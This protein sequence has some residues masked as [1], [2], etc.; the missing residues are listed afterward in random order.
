MNKGVGI[1]GK[2]Y[3]IMFRNDPHAADSVDRVLT[4][5]MIKLD[6]SSVEYLYGPYTDLST[7]YTPGSRLFF[8]TLAARLRG[9][10]DS[11]TVDNIILFCRN[12]VANCDTDT[13]EMIFGGTEEEIVE[14]GTDWCTDIARVACLLF[15]V[16]GLPSRILNTANTKFA[17]SGHCVAEVYYD[18]KWGVA[19]PTNGIV[20]RHLGG[21]PASAWD[22]QNDRRVAN[23]FTTGEQYASVG[24]SNYYANDKGLYNYATSRVNEYYRAVLKHSAQ[25][26]P[27]GIRWIHGE[28]QT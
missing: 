14:R 8:D 28:D 4:E 2:Q 5:Q 11:D 3:E 13:E 22:L 23:R 26:W 15:Q 24:I 10:T 6:G 16:A 25:Q 12:I 7:R 18:T 27:G 20:F 1:F 19:D 21:A 17:Y 9:R